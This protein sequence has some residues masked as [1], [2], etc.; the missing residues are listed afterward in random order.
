MVFD[1]ETTGLNPQ[2]DEV[3]QIAAVRV[4]N[5]KLVEGERFDMLVNPGRKT[6][7]ASTAV[8]AR[9]PTR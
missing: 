8:P 5:G 9:S 1:T 2:V 7:A 3:C 6:P 4:V